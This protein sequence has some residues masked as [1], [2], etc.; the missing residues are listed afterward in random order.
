[1]ALADALLEADAITTKT[2]FAARARRRSGAN[3]CMARSFRDH[4][5]EAGT[6]ASAGGEPLDP[7]A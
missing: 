2:P 1:M 7:L 6:F 4:G 3:A 5:G